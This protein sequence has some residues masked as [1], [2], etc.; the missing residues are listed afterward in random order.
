[1]NRLLLASIAALAFAG[2]AAAAQ[3]VAIVNARL[4]TATSAGA[5]ITPTSG[6]VA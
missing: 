3:T 1:M 2:A 6:G 5:M 4:E